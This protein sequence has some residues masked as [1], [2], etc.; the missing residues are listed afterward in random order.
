MNIAV[1]VSGGV[2]SSVALKLLKD[3]GYE[4]T[5]FY[6][7]IWLE[8]EVSYLGQCP[9]EEDLRYVTQVCEQLSVT[10]KVVNM[11]KQYWD[12]I[13][14]YTIDEVRAGRTPSPDIFCNKRI[15]FG[16]FF[17]EVAGKFDK[18]ATGHY[19]QIEQ[20]ANK[21]FLKKAVD[22]FKDQTYFLSHLNQEQLSK[23]LFPI[24]H[25]KKEQVRSIAI[26][27]NLPNAKRKDSQGICFLG[28]IKFGDF[29]KQYLGEKQGDFVEIET[30]IVVGQHEG[31]WFYTVG[32][33]KGIG[34][35]GGPWYVVS[36]DTN[37]NIVYISNKYYSDEKNRKEFFVSDFNWILGI[38]PEDKNLKVKIRHG[39]YLY[40]CEL[41][42]LDTNKAKVILD[43]DDQGIASGQFAV[44]YEG[45]I[46]LGCG[47]IE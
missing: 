12:K 6:L 15:K 29:I 46:C 37:N 41:I 11:Q 10:L 1:L 45:E 32:Q 21:F 24:G 18:I 38:A 26:E 28:K 43:K 39:E 23:I 2:D 36:K 13:V 7:K 44:F 35:S 16:A 27:N 25:L 17:D 9:W 30:G 5:A 47:K 40:N 20:K 3:Q 22:S 33:R 42:F 14:S 4:L 31:F 8:D 19:A 34:L